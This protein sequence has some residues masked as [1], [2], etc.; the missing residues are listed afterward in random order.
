MSAPVTFKRLKKKDRDGRDYLVRWCAVD[1][2]QIK[3]CKSGGEETWA[4]YQD[5]YPV[6]DALNPVYVTAMDKELQNKIQR[7]LAVAE[8]AS[9][10]GVT[11]RELTSLHIIA[12][13]INRDRKHDTSERAFREEVWGSKAWYLDKHCLI[14]GE[15]SYGAVGLT[16]QILHTYKDSVHCPNL[17]KPWHE[18]V[19]KLLKAGLLQE[20]IAVL[21]KTGVPEPEK[22]CDAYV[23]AGCP[24]FY[25]QQYHVG[26]R[27]ID[28]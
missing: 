14:C 4:F 24:K 11:L 22:K 12:Q 5:S 3:H 13:T 19:E 2:G 10:D 27:T 7:L 9:A 1:I 21:G 6:Y 16:L 20:A 26:T 15:R 23:K 18:R 8:G 25:G 17:V 28:Q